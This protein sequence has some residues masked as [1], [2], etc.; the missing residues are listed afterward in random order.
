MF[1]EGPLVIFLQNEVT[2]IIKIAMPYDESKCFYL[3]LVLVFVLIIVSLFVFLY[4]L[5]GF[6][7]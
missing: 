4:F 7:I 6:A 5:L 2:H 1:D 3:F